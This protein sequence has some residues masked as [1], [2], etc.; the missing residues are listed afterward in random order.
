MKRLYLH[1]GFNKTGSTTLQRCLFRNSTTLEQAGILYPG[2][3]HDSYMQNY[4]HTPLAAALPERQVSWLRPGKRASLDRALRDLL[5]RIESSAAETVVISSEAFGGIDMTQDRVE[6]VQR[7]LAQFDTRII[8]YIRR[9]DEYFLST[10]QEEIKNGGRHAFQFPR[11]ATNRQ[12]TF[13][14]RLAPWRAV[15]GADRVIVR[16]FERR[17][18]PDGNLEYDFFDIIGAPLDNLTPM[19]KP[20]NE[21][22]SFCAL[23]FMRQLNILGAQESD[24]ALTQ[25][26]AQKL[27]AAYSQ[28]LLVE[29]SQQKMALSSDQAET[30]RDHFRDDNIAALEGSGIGV[31]EFF[32]P[33][34]PGRTALLQP[35]SPDPKVLLRLLARQ[36]Q[37]T[38]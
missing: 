16:P 18:W 22:L 32:P 33:V 24:F 31:D 21:S 30:L 1:I 10:Y 5:A 3:L 11:Y 9:Q 26:Q 8:A 14:Q 2:R 13:S 27:T 38:S 36:I 6:L 25:A 37:T 35:Q 28:V 34:A 15:F 17:F 12:F 29:E 7:K 19:E 23:E 20:A 4:Q